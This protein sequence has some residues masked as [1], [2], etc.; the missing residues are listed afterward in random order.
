MEEP[1]L[2]GFDGRH[3]PAD[4]CFSTVGR[5]HGSATEEIEARHVLSPG[6]GTFRIT[7]G[8][9]ARPGYVAISGSGRRHALRVLSDHDAVPQ[10][11]ITGFFA[12]ASWWW[13]QASG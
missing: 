10:I 7:L 8:L 2:S 6:V 4:R 1:A 3:G 13:R 5:R 11:R 9:R 12:L